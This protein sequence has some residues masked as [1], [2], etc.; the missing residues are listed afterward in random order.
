MDL[1]QERIALIDKEKPLMDLFGRQHTYLRISLTEKCNLRCTY[2]MPE[3][4]VELS[5]PEHLLTSQEINRL[6]KLFV[7]Q[8][9]TKIRLTGGEPTIRKDFLQIVQNLND[10]RSLGLKKLGITTNGIALK[11]KLPMLKEY[12]LDQINISLV[13]QILCR[14]PSIRTYLRL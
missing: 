5:P 2:C 8:G 4:G 9:I 13:F 11:R 14:I 12:G 6:A 10:L 7:Q 1:I 3:G